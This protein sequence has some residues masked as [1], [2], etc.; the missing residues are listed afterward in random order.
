M[1]G[2][3]NFRFIILLNMAWNKGHNPNYKTIEDCYR[4][5]FSIM[6]EKLLMSR[7]YL[8]AKK[9][10][11]WT[12]QDIQMYHAFIMTLYLTGGRISEV[13]DI[14]L[15]DIQISEDKTFLKILIPTKKLRNNE[16][17]YRVIPIYIKDEE[18]RFAVEPLVIWFNIKTDLSE[19]GN[20]KL[21]P[22]SRYIGYNCCI[23]CGFNPHFLRKIF[24]TQKAT[25]YN[26]SIPVLQKLSGHRSMDNLLPYLAI[27][28]RD[29]EEYLKK[30][31][32]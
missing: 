20:E 16:K 7:D 10:K 24:I 9:K 12:E 22:F 8:V 11:S 2:L 28:T 32:S 6:K 19:D 5:T 1:V 21:F 4:F 30:G 29:I 17:G 26:M 31:K 23:L 14:R 25:I 15:S 18:Y 3:Y 27:D 13:L